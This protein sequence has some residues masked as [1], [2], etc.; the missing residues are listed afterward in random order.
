MNVT[1]FTCLF[2][3]AGRGSSYFYLVFISNV[4]LIN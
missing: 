1:G 3:T 4:T 2:E